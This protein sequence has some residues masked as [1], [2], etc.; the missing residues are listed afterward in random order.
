[1][2]PDGNNSSAQKGAASL[3]LIVAVF[4]AAAALT[5]AVAA[6][7]IN[8]Q[9]R[10]TEA[11]TPFTWLADVD[12]NTTDPEVWGRTF[13]LQYD[14]YLKTVDSTHTRFGGSE[15]L[16]PQKAERD[17]WLT[18]LYAGYAFS[19][20]YRER[21]GHAYMLEDQQKTLRVK[22]RKQPGAC[23][24]CHSSIIPAYRFK[25]DGDVMKG[26]DIVNAMPYEEAAAI[27]D[28]DGK[29]LIEHP[30]SCVD[31]HEPK[32]MKVRVTRP[33]FI[34]GIKQYKASQGIADYDV[35][36]DATR[37][38]LRA[39]ACG[40]CHVEYYF[41][42]EGKTLTYPWHNGLKADDVEKYYDDVQFNDW[43]HAETGAGVIKAQHPEFE[44]WNQGIHA[45]AGVACV[46]CHMPYMRI[47]AGKTADHWVR[48]P[49]LNINRACQ[50]CHN[51]SESEIKAR[52]DN[53]QDKTYALMKEA[54]K[55]YTDMLDS[56]V[57]AKNAGA[58]DD[59]L[60]PS[61]ALQRK[62]QWRLD[63]V[64]S[65]NSMGFH[66]PQEAMRLLAESI[67]FSRQGQI[68]AMRVSAAK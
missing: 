30:V 28:A 1:M 33:G 6:L 61:L 64:S 11:Y 36:R 21:R 68:A 59:A 26:F 16:P 13:P 66:A 67:D 18:R 51:V 17:P 24:H 19:L 47:G 35:N 27:A 12:E 58:S 5:A 50:P 40:Q 14:N 32:T 54:A 20:D 10:K 29:K 38:E 3:L 57:A 49:L 62:A 45:R 53:I 2:K 46:D 60:V 52:V 63:Y 48:S 15:A 25:G 41:K 8:I 31:C 55:A 22:E 56:V 43:T 4:I 7:L 65:E 39:Y 42:G 34:N 37:A 9:S 44:M 23:L